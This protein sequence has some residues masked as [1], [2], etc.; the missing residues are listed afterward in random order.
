M[1]ENQVNTPKKLGNHNKHRWVP[2]T[3][4]AAIDR[5]IYCQFISSLLIPALHANWNTWVILVQALPAGFF[6]NVKHIHTQTSNLNKLYKTE[7]K[8][9][10]KV[11]LLHCSNF[12]KLLAYGGLRIFSLTKP[13]HWILDRSLSALQH[14]ANDYH[15]MVVLYYQAVAEHPVILCCNSHL[16]LVLG[17]MC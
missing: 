8:R 16:P 10:V 3:V 7:Y 5:D 13:L 17:F 11:I 14:K 2:L 1:Q 15:L 12:D 6:S 4:S 9:E